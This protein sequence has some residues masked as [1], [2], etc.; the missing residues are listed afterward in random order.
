M[1][2]QTRR[3]FLAVDKH[4][5]FVHPPKVPKLRE[6]S[7]AKPLRGRDLPGALGRLGVVLQGC[8]QGIGLTNVECYATEIAARGC[9]F[10]LD[11]RHEEGLAAGN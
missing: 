1:D 5:D 11:F 4:F 9:K 8:D 3:A 6:I 10:D 7:S 2:L